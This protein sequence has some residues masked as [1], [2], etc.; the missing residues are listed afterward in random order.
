MKKSISW[1][2]LLLIG[3]LAILVGR[4]LGGL[5][6]SSIGVFGDIVFLIG[7]VNMISFMVKRRQENKQK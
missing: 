6:G 2:S 7:L 1:K 3:V 4:T 5:V